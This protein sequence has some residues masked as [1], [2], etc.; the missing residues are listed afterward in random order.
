MIVVGLTGS[1]G[2]GKTTAANVFRRLRIPVHDADVAVHRLFAQ[3]GAAVA[4][5]EAAFPGVARNG[6]IDRPALGKRVFQDPEALTRL[7]IIVHPLVR[8]DS[9]A[10]L[11]RCA[12]RREP[13]AVLDVP[14]LFETGRD[15]DCDV[16]VVVSAPQFIQRQ[17]VLRRPGMT[18]ER[19]DEIRARQMPDREKTRR[20]DFTVRTG[21]GRHESLLAL[22]HIVKLLRASRRLHRRPPVWPPSTR[23][24]FS[25]A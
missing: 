24:P 19:L 17:R 16:T 2:M 1:I 25:D 9:L 4:P 21:L 8:V 13:V 7:E 15:R 10:F 20:A 23:I 5:V 22:L 6:A 14:L 11:Q 3:G 18:R 12:I